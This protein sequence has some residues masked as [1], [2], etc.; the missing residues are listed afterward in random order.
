M[1][2]SDSSTPDP[3][4]IRQSL[5]ETER[6]RSRL[7]KNLLHER[8]PLIAG[9]YVKQPGRC[10]KPSCKCARGEFHSAAALYT[11]QE[12]VQTC[13][14]VQQADRERLEK[15]NRRYR[16]ARKIRAELAKLGQQSLKLADSLLQALTEP[17]PPANRR[18]KQ[19]KRTRRRPQRKEPSR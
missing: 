8:G 6:R 15:L 1:D 5:G 3:P 7:V 18:N 13:T 12:G 2:D 4:R 17:Y 11:R 10:G 14:Y 19:R 16:Q 9:S